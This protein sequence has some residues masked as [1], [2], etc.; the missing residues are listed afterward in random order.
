MS[1]HIHGAFL[2]SFHLGWYGI[3]FTL[4]GSTDPTGSV[5]TDP[6]IR[7]GFAVFVNPFVRPIGTTG[8]TGVTSGLGAIIATDE[9]YL[10]TTAHELGHALNLLHED[11]DG[12]QTIMNRTGDL[13]INWDYRWNDRSFEHLNHHPVDRIQPGIPPGATTAVDFAQCHDTTTG[14]VLPC[15]GGCVRGTPSC[16]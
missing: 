9:G 15:P 11:G 4:A 7:T 13:G 12:S 3:M 1:R 16:P 8:V 2:P 5:I 10:R 6:E 14:C